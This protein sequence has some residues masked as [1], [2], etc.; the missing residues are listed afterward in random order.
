MITII[1]AGKIGTSVA[2]DLITRN[3]DDILFIDIVKGL[4]QGE[5]LD[6]SH[7]AASNGIDRVIR[8]TNNYQD[9]EESEIIIVTAGFPRMPG[10]TRID[11][12]NKNTKI[13][14]DISQK[15]SKYA[16][17]SIILMVTNPL[18]IMTYL[19]LKVTGF[20]NEKVMGMG[21]MLDSARF[22]YFISNRLDVS[23]A[24]VDALVIG[25]HGENMLPLAKHSKV[26]G[27]PLTEIMSRDDINKVIDETRKTAAEIISLKGGTVYAPGSAVG[28]MVESIIR[29][30]RNIMPTS[31]FLNGEYDVS[32]LCIGVPAII[33][34]EGISETIELDLSKEENNI[35]MKGADTL[36]RAISEAKFS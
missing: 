28:Q 19:A 6:L 11:L 15:I 10:M 2:S 21:G 32:D 24:S 22:R 31:V 9:I 35:F 16:S 20:K 18:D 1:G 13:I 36:R 29:D 14:S 3:L 23:R 27:K 25:E 4:P 17:D 30:K 34:K 7:M 8:G 5:A 26:D 12:L 33:S